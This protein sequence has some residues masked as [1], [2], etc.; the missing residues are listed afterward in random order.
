MDTK[1]RYS[2][3]NAMIWVLILVGVI[4]AW[5]NWIEMIPSNTVR[6]IAAFIL[7]FPCGALLQW[8]MLRKLGWEVI[9]EKEKEES[10]SSDKTND[11]PY[12]FASAFGTFERGLY[13]ILLLADKPEALFIWLGFKA[14]AKWG[15]HEYSP[16]W[17]FSKPFNLSLIGELLN[18]FLALVGI[19]LIKGNTNTL[20][21]FFAK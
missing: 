17:K 9:I 11:A 4:F 14:I 1:C 19:L 3:F 8:F 2:I 6:I 20:I 10:D 7:V 13:L 16:Q 15:Q 18:I 12:K 21:A 5:V